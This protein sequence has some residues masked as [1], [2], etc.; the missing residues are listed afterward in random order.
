[1]RFFS[2]FSPIGAY[3]DLRTFLLSRERYE[4]GF[5]ALAIAITGVFVFAF[6]ENS[7]VEAPYKR[8]IIYVQQW[9]ADRTDTQIRAQQLIDQV[10]RDRQAAI[11]KAEREKR[12][13][14]FKRLDDSLTN[15]GI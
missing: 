11:D 8:E 1:M 5:L 7:R 10:E 13:A 15:M 12:Q 14:E 4:L 2:R 9:R 6:L 3:R